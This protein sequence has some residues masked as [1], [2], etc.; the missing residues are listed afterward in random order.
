[1]N[2]NAQGAVFVRISHVPDLLDGLSLRFFFHHLEFE[3]I[4]PIGEYHGHV[5]PAA[6]GGF[7]GA[8]IQT[9]RREIAVEYADVKAFVL[10]DSA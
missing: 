3:D 1:V 8:D 10:G 6:A 9:Q 7:L 2:E 4:H 5:D